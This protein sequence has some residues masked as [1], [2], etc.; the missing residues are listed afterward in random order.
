MTFISNG[1]WLIDLVHRSVVLIKERYHNYKHKD[2]VYKPVFV[3][4]YEF[5]LGYHQSYSLVIFL[6]CLLFSSSVPLITFFAA[7]FFWIKYAVDKYNLIF[8]YFKIFESGGKIRKIVTHYMI[9]NLF[10]Y[11]IVTVSF[12]SLKFSTYYMWG[13]AIIVIAW[14]AFAIIKKKIKHQY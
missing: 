6:N 5:D 14:I 8:V 4:D 11:L 10:F 2:S 12:F 9:F 13:C 3:D 7:L 1:V